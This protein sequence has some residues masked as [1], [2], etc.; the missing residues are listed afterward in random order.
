MGTFPT[1][2]SSNPTFASG[3]FTT[4]AFDGERIKGEWTVTVNAD[5]IGSNLLT[6]RL[7]AQVETCQ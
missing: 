6:T 2:G 1:S 7:V 3:S 5:A 4:D